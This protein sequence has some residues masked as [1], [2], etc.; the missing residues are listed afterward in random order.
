[1]HL[2]KFHALISG[3]ALEYTKNNINTQIQ[4]VIQQLDSLAANPGNTE[5]AKAFKTQIE[6]LRTVLS[7]SSM[8]KPYP[9]LAALLDSINAQQY[10]GDQLFQN[11]ENVI[12]KNGMSPQLAAASL[13][14]FMA[15]VVSF[16]QEITAIDNAF[17]QLEVEYS[18]LDSGEGE[19][20]ISI[21]KPEGKRLLSDLAATAKAW[22]RALRPFV[23][24]ADPNHEPVEVRTISSSDWQFYLT[25]GVTV[26]V[27]LSGAVSQ[28][29]TLLQKMVE[30]KKLIKQLAGQGMSETSTAPLMLEVE[31]MLN[32]G[33]RQLAEKIVEKNP[34]ADKGRANELKTEM[35]RSLGFIASQMAVNVTIEI[36]YLPPLPPERLEENEDNDADHGAAIRIEQ[37]TEAAAQIERN[38]DIIRLDSDGQALLNLPAPDEGES[39]MA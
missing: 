20:G 22:D 30:T 18:K 7:L 4:S 36:R 21:P 2:G 28:L 26:L 11:I 6:V 15:K 14:E 25:A 31:N 38:M 35:T 19:I 1:M 34:S 12:E 9:T 32:S 24:L 8:N 23:E 39:N 27:T 16:Y 37:L 17:T 29:N 10:V 5:I 13:R 3:L 33:T